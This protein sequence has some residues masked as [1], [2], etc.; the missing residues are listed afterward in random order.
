MY[1]LVVSQEQSLPSV[2]VFSNISW[3]ILAKLI[4]NGCFNQHAAT[5][6]YAETQNV[7][8]HLFMRTP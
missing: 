7:M 1:W 4:I 6:T 8:L 2:K 3:N 5:A